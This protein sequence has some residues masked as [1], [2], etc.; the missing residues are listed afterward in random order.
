MR[1]FRFLGAAARQTTRG[2]TR[3]KLNALY[4][5]GNQTQPSTTATSNNF[6]NLSN[7]PSAQTV[8][9]SSEEI[10]LTVNGVHTLTA[11]IGDN[12]NYI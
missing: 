9:S 3:A 5:Y 7:P 1:T 11:N 4:G 10:T 12:L 8:S 2:S 6:T